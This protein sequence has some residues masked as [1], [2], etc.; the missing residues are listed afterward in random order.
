MYPK[1][2]YVVSDLWT[3]LYTVYIGH[4][5]SQAC[6]FMTGLEVKRFSMENCKWQYNFILFHFNF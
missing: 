6:T 4:S 5:Q 2:F 1:I 3:A